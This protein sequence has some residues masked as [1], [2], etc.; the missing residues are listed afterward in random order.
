VVT[1]AAG[2]DEAV[3]DFSRNW[4][5]TLTAINRFGAV[6]ECWIELCEMPSINELVV[7]EGFPEDPFAGEICGGGGVP[8]GGTA[9]SSVDDDP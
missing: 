5:L 4:R 7:A 3:E 8:I 9:S 1:G 6:E 2:T